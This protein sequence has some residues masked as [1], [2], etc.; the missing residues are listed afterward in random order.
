MVNL[1]ENGITTIFLYIYLRFI[2]LNYENNLIKSLKK[3]LIFSSTMNN[4]EV[5]LLN[6]IIATYG[7]VPH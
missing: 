3:S 5:L 6:W 2:I 1:M 4:F 7:T